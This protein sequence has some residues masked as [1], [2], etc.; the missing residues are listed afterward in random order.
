[1]AWLRHL[2]RPAAS[3]RLRRDLLLAEVEVLTGQV[4][5]IEQE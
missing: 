3:Q 2:E 5:C 4:R 1:L